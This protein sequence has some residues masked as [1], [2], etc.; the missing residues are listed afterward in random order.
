MLTYT[1][2]NFVGGGE[3]ESLEKVTIPFCTYLDSC[4]CLGLGG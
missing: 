2:L 1:R 4:E 3:E